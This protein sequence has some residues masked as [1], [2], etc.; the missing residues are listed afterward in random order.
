VDSGLP[1]SFTEFS[2]DGQ[3]RLAV[4]GE[5]DIATAPLLLAEIERLELD[6][7]HTLALDLGGVTFMD[8]A[9]MRVLLEAAQRARTRDT[10]LVIFNPRRCASRVFGLTAVDQ[11]LEIRFDEHEHEHA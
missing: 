7:P 4:A 9:G 11:Q 1:L 3:L 2:V 5:L 8:V 10:S 6:R